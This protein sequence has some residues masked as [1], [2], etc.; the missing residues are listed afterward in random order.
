MAKP[1]LAPTQATMGATE[2]PTSSSP[3]EAGPASAPAAGAGS[4]TPS[5]PAE[6]Y[7][8]YAQRVARWAYNLGG[9]DIG[10][11]DVVQEVFLVVTRKWT[12]YRAQGS[13]TSWL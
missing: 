2:A 1:M 11:E 12:S 13:F 7:R 3:R 4:A 5:C 10:A 8:A 9:S 6:A